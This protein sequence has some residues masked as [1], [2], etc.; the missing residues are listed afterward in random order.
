[1]SE[2]DSCMGQLWM[3]V[4]GTIFYFEK[5]GQ[6]EQHLSSST[7]CSIHQTLMMMPKE[8]KHLVNKAWCTGKDLCNVFQL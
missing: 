6:C 7:L 1:M 4:N 3:Q 8:S 2:M 5:Q